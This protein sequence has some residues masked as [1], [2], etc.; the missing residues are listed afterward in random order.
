MSQDYI[1]LV[2]ASDENYAKYTA[3]TLV[4][5]CKNFNSNH[6]MR[7]FVLTAEPLSPAS[8]DNF[9]RIKRF[10]EF[11]FI[12]LIVD[13]TQ[14]ENIKT[15]PGI[16]VATYFRLLMHDLLPEDV[17]GALYLDSD[18]I[19]RRC[20]SEV[21]FSDLSGHLIG[22]VQD[23]ISKRYN[24]KFGIA[25]DAPHINA[26]VTLLDIEAIRKANFADR[27]N[28]Y[29]DSHRYLITLG[30][31][32]IINAVFHREIKYLP[33][34]WN[35]HGSMFDRGWRRKNI[36]V[37]NSFTTSEIRRAVHNP[38]IIHFTFMRK[39]WISSEH[40][41]TDEWFKYAKLTP[42]FSGKTLSFIQSNCLGKLSPDRIEDSPAIKIVSDISAKFW[43]AFKSPEKSLP[44]LRKLVGSSRFL[45]SKARKTQ[46]SIPYHILEVLSASQLNEVGRRQADS[47]FDANKFVENM[48]A[49]KKFYT[50][51]EDRDLNG[52]FHENIKTILKTPNISR[53]EDISRVDAVLLLVERLRQESFWK[54]LLIAI[55]YER[56]IL[57]AE[58]TFFGALSTYFD[59]SAPPEFRR[60]FGYILD[61]MGFYFDARNPSRLETFLNSDAARLSESELE[62]ARSLIDRIVAEGITKYNYSSSR[63]IELD[64]PKNSVLIVDQKQGDA[65]IEFAAASRQ[66]FNLMVD[67]AVRENPGVSIYLKAHPDNLGKE[68]GISNSYVR[69]LP[70]NVSAVTILGQCEKVYVVSSQLGFEALLRG[71]EVH[72]FGMPFYSGWGLT[73]DR[74]VIPRRTHV[75]SI[76]ELFYAACIKHSVYINP[77]IGSI[78]QIEEAFD[79]MREKLNK[80]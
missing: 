29:L 59:L 10:K 68:T 75:R 69:I 1:N 48:A 78:V 71:K 25:I 12:N 24:E 36:G 37:S 46:S 53:T 7:V 42:A 4:S 56:D 64:I 49:Y 14:F 70:S 45:M 38:A 73:V 79:W 6:R 52:G 74:Q 39:P 34:E 66:T 58:T 20:I 80:G 23:S 35:V 16:T 65:S 26:G 17:G 67:A 13:A 33:V 30:D 9:I 41:K 60:C 15:T 31:Q 61:D 62:R 76:E 55:R 28:R 51:G 50:N 22:G 5:I 77:D 57:F 27:I 2:F 21:Y 54:A 32:Q 18:L 19:V 47:E 63:P 72:V 43:A 40:P 44:M 8:I 3:T 11:E